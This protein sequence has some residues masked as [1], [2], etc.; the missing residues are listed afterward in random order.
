MRSACTRDT[1]GGART[2]PLDKPVH[3]VIVAT[4]VFGLSIAVMG[5]GAPRASAVDLSGKA[6][7]LDP[8]HNG[9]SDPSAAAQVPNGR[10]GTKDC[11]TTG[12]STASGYS[13]H[14]FNWDVAQRI[15]A[16]LD[17]LG[18][19]TETSR[20]S[21]GSFGPC[22]DQRAAM[23][24]AMHPDAIIS[25]HADGGPVSGHGFHVN[26]SAPPLKDVQAGPAVSLA[27]TMRDA[28]ASAGIR[29]S[30]YIGSN[31]LYGRA[32][33]AGLNLSEYPAVLVEMG[34]MRN[35]DDA[36]QMESPDGRQRYADAVT[37]GIVAY[38]SHL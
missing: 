34:N 22:V 12:T 14:L 30:D 18:V 13:E 5:L 37:Q 36:A 21:D 17:T 26:Y 16:A 33:L 20:D 2:G 9:L 4:C 8:G 23:A 29:E 15:R 24:N 31:G 27:T 11:N 28:L 7:F 10:G 25:I 3:L 6:V 38:L 19:R 35:A 1:S 32:D